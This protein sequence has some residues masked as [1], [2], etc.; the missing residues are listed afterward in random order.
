[1]TKGVIARAT[2]VAAIAAAMAVTIATNYFTVAHIFRGATRVPWADEWPIL[3]QFIE[4][5]HGSPLW[6]L[7]WRSHWGHRFVIPRLVYF[8]DIQWA[9]HAPL[10]WLTLSLQSIL[11][12]QICALSWILIGRKSRLLFA[13]SLA[14]I[15]NLMISPLQMENFVWSMQFTFPLVYSA[16]CASFLFLAL[17]TERASFV[18]FPLAISAAMVASLSMAN[19]IL[20][21]PVLA[22]QAI[23][24]RLPRRVTAAIAVLGVAI[25]A[26]YCFDYPVHAI[27]MGIPGMLRHPVDASLLLGLLLG[28]ALNPIS[29]PLGIGASLLALAGAVYLGCKRLPEPLAARPWLSALAAVLIFVL[30]SAASTVAG[31]IT[32]QWLSENTPVPSRCFTLVQLFWA[33]LSILILYEASRK[34]GS[35]LLVV[36]C[37]A[38]YLSLMFLNPQRQ[39]SAALDWPDF[40]RGVD[41]VGAALIA[42]VPDERFLSIL[43]PVDAE[44]DAIVP[45]LRERQ[46]SVFAEPRATWIGRRVSDLYPPASANH[47]IGEIER[48]LEIEASPGETSW[49]VE[50]WAWNVSANRAFGYLLIVDPAKIVVGLARGGFHHTYFPGFFTADQTALPPHVRFSASE[51]LGYVRE[52]M[53]S[54][55]TVYGVQPDSN[56]VCIIQT[57]A[58]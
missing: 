21:W 47:C 41:A 37:A 10:I 6:P 28:G 11:I 42:G 4:Y 31:R 48:S 58:H 57:A 55:W 36:P 54:T 24:L 29:L 35:R 12:A 25:I 3:Q 23:Y 39:I 32:P 19:G 2:S 53:R 49:R 34:P 45:F 5:Q 51:W 27:G 20:V 52:P 26:A 46:L 9:A 44:R 33:A 17:R 14:V 8:A 16:A 43:W 30:L 18:F 40:F 50:G 56:Q 1:V 22:G 15:L 7:L 13:A 38:L